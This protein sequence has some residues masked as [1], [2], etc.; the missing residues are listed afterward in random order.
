MRQSDKYQMDAITTD[1]AWMR[2]AL[3]G[4]CITREDI[5]TPQQVIDIIRQHRQLVREQN[6][7]GGTG[8]YQYD[9]VTGEVEMLDVAPHSH[10][11]DIGIT[12]NQCVMKGK[13]M[14]ARRRALM[15]LERRRAMKK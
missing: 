15:E 10:S 6:Y 13:A 5:T 2:P 8:M 9:H 3:G 11:C 4:G 14:S 1:N 7:A 12:K